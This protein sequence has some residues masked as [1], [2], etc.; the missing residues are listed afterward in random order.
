VHDLL[1]LGIFFRSEVQNFKSSTFRKLSL[2]YGLTLC[3]VMCNYRV[4]CHC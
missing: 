2:V 4:C 1:C 3:Y